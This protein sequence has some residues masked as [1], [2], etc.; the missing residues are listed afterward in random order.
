MERESEP[1]LSLSDPIINCFWSSYSLKILKQLISLTVITEK[2]YPIKLST[3]DGLPRFVFLILF[4]LEK[5]DF[6]LKGNTIITL[7]TLCSLI[8]SLRFVLFSET[9]YI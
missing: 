7:L 6:S 1:D 9:S 2:G 5:C 8:M 4:S 3:C